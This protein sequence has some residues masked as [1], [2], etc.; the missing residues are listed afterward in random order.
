MLTD[1]R[2]ESGDQPIPHMP[3]A[4]V[5]V[6]I[7]P[8]MPNLMPK[9]L[10]CR[11]LYCT[12]PRR[13]DCRR[14]NQTPAPHNRLTYITNAIACL[15]PVDQHS[16]VSTAARSRRR[17]MKASLHTIDHQIDSD[18][19]W[20]LSTCTWGNFENFTSRFQLSREDVCRFPLE[21]PF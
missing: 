10:Q 18:C 16:A 13:I 21:H 12:A 9:A 20:G 17:T 14:I 8:G 19:V 11:V 15:V 6:V 5:E 4:V 7:A 3:C 1:I 2:R